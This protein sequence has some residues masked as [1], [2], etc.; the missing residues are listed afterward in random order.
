M[1]RSMI[2]GVPLAILLGCH[3][4]LSGEEVHRSRREAVARA[5]ARY[6]H[7]EK[8]HLARPGETEAA[9]QLAQACFERAEFATN[10]VE[11]ALLAQQGIAPCRELLA[12]GVRL[13]P[14]HYYL[15]MNLGQLARTKGLG[16]L[17]LVDEMEREFKMAQALDE[18]LEHAGPDRC[19]GLLY[20]EAPRIG[21]IGNRS[22]ARQHLQKAV[23]LAP[24]YPENR[25]NLA[26]ACLKW[27][28][29]NQARRELKALEASWKQARAELAGPDW[30]AHWFDWDARLV[31]LQQSIEALGQ[32]DAR[33]KF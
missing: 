17:R 21:S 24:D 20:L 28:E 33:R 12:R 4:T 3:I 23:E 15:A 18:H 13:A 26:E 29:H 16:A 22:R 7:A 31:R 10:N 19:L 32:A 2:C 8:E 30:E 11:R 27:A 25:L 1:N 6:V 14:V 9:W 5:Q